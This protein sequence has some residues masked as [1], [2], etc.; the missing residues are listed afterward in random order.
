MRRTNWMIVATFSVVTF[1]AGVVATY[2]V[3]E[4]DQIGVVTADMENDEFDEFLNVLDQLRHLHYFYD[5]ETDLIRGAI[6][7]MIEATGDSYAGFFTRAEFDSTMRHLQGSFYGI[8]AEVTSIN[9]DAVIVSPLQGSPAETYGVLPGD[10]IISVDGENVREYDLNE[11]IDRI[12]GEDGTVVS[13]E[14]LRAGTDLIYIDVTRG[15]IVNET[16]TTNIFKENGN[17][18]GY[19]RVSSFGETT[20]NDFRDA[21]DELDDYGIDG[22]IVDLRDNPGG[23]LTTVNN[24][25]SYLLPSGLNITS[26][27]DRDGNLQAHRTRGDSNYRLDVPILTIINEGSASASELFAAAM[28][29]SGGFEVL[30]TTSFGK[31][32]VQSSLPIGRDGDS[33]LQL[34]I[35]AWLTPDGNLIDGEGVEPTIYV[36][37]SESRHFLQV[38]LEGEELLVYDMVHPGVKSAQLILDLLGY[39]LDRTDGYF[40]ATTVTAVISFQQNNDL[41]PTGDIDSE[42]ATALTMGL[43]DH[44]RD[45]AYDEQIQAAIEWFE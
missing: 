43:R 13:L 18:I 42:T 22:L 17:N 41:S 1:I 10:V 32:T 20:F 5:E 24:M 15:R 6:D 40:D 14:I 3:L 2:A 23:L 39:S 45:P 33:T 36:P 4:F 26:A 37:A 11:V 30:G 7:G 44:T 34:T 19:I 8:G 25:V 35:Q 12:R 27:V 31:G 29:E 9:G 21:V 16:V 28:M 38:H